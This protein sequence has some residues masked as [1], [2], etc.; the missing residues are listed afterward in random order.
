MDE[1]VRKIRR[2]SQEVDLPSAE[3]S[4]CESKTRG[5]W[6]FVCELDLFGFQK[7]RPH[8]LLEIATVILE[9]RRLRK[10]INNSHFQRRTIIHCLRF[11]L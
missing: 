8:I 3:D 11:K 10:C 1:V 5:L 4:H 2:K 9:L 7:S 6:Y